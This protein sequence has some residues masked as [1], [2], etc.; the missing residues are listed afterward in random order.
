MIPG[1]VKSLLFL[2]E[3]QL[4][5]RIVPPKPQP[6]SLSKA[7]ERFAHWLGVQISAADLPRF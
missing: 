2:E 4:S 7:S 5:G 6:A 1:S 3:R